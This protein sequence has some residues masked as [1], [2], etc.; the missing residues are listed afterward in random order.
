M[1]ILPALLLDRSRVR[2]DARCMA[3]HIGCLGSV[4]RPHVKTHTSIGG[5]RDVNEA[6]GALIILS[7]TRTVFEYMHRTAEFARE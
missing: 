4:L 1:E 5:Y 2:D 3:G 7:A 6:G